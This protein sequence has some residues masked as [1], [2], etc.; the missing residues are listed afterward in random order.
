MRR[1]L[2]LAIFLTAHAAVAQQRKISVQEFVAPIYPPI[3]KQAH[4]V[5]DVKLHFDVSPGGELQDVQVVTGH[6]ML[7]QAALDA[8]AKWRFHCDDCAYNE[9]FSHSFIFSFQFDESEDGGK[10]VHYDF[11]G[12]LTIYAEPPVFT[13]E[14]A[15]TRPKFFWLWKLFHPKSWH[16]HDYDHDWQDTSE[17]LP[18]RK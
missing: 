9:T 18:S 3:A 15:I 10:D 8:I 11:P 13:G 2:V 12:R 4:I 1:L 17:P 6:P 7:A 5:G 14:V 16:F